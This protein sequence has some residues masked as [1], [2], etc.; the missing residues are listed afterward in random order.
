MVHHAL[1]DQVLV[2]ENQEFFSRD[3]WYSPFAPARTKRTATCVI[4]DL[5]VMATIS[6]GAGPPRLEQ[7]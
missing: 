2:F 3:H 1:L 4:P 6:R 5:A 7:V